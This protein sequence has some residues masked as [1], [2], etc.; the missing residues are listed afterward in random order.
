MIPFIREVMAQNAAL[1]PSFEAYVRALVAP[2][3][4]QR[5]FRVPGMPDVTPEMLF[6]VNF[7]ASQCDTIRSGGVG[8]LARRQVRYRVALP[9]ALRVNIPLRNFDRFAEVFMCPN[10]SYMNPVTK[11]RLW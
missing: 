1:Q 9:S 3:S 11:C 7:A 2:H 6:F 8:V 4:M 10:G 5:N